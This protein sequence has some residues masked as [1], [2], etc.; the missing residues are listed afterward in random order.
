MT[1]VSIPAA[2][3]RSSPAAPGRFEITMPICASS[4]PS[5]IA[6]ISAWRLLPRPEMRT[7]SRAERVPGLALSGAG[8]RNPLA[9]ATDLADLHRAALGCGGQRIDDLRSVLPAARDDQA[10]PHIES[11]QHVVVRHGPR[12]LQP[13]EDRGH[14][15]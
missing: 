1:S 2:A 8:I 11:P 12:P 6:S 3:A 14:G 15:P 7:P 13:L 5:P 9:A 10:D 4:R